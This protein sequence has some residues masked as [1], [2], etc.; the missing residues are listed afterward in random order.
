MK[1][2]I[3]LVIVFLLAG[4][5]AQ[6]QT[7]DTTIR[8]TAPHSRYAVNADATVTDLRT[9]LVWQRCPAGAT[10]HDNG[11]ADVYADDRCE[12]EAEQTYLWQAALQFAADLNLGGGFAGFSDWRVPNVKELFSLVERQCQ[13]PAINSTVFPLPRVTSTL[14]FWSSSPGLVVDFVAG[15]ILQEALR[16]VDRV[17]GAYRLWLVR[18]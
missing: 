11:T 1:V 12:F 7:C 9:G 5:S 10:L 17:D 6:A 4:V 3:S 14:S 8:A 13:L 15:A 2:Q 18:Q 16:E